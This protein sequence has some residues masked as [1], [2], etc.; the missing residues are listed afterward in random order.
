MRIN[1]FTAG[2]DR[3]PLPGAARSSTD[4][5]GSTNWTGW[6]SDSPWWNEWPWLCVGS[7]YRTRILLVG[8]RAL[9]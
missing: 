5:S 2:Q 7:S 9:V 8:L 6:F 3:G 1:R 4:L